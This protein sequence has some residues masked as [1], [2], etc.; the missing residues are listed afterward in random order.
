[1]ST[2]GPRLGVV[3]GVVVTG[4]ESSPIQAATKRMLR[5]S[6]LLVFFLLVFSVWFR[7]F[8]KFKVRALDEIAEGRPAV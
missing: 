8:P 5:S 6:K 4:E 7:S 3:L 1:M 2:S